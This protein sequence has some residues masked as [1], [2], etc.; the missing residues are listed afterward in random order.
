M[1]TPQCALP[2]LTPT[3]SPGP[4]SGHAT[5]PVF[6]SRVNISSHV[7]SFTIIN[8]LTILSISK[9]LTVWLVSTLALRVVKLHWLKIKIIINVLLLVLY[10]VSFSLETPSLPSPRSGLLSLATSYSTRSPSSSL[11]A[12]FSST[13]AGSKSSISLP[14]SSPSN[15]GP[16]KC[17]LPPPVQSQVYFHLHWTQLLLL[18]FHHRTSLPCHEQ[19]EGEGESLEIIVWSVHVA[20]SHDYIFQDAVG[21]CRA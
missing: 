17:L 12:V 13:S 18:P 9:T 8:L 6:P 1:S 7:T 19:K 15:P 21:R 14:S 11:S 20:S 16:R 10:L 4:P 3:S 2:M 5:L